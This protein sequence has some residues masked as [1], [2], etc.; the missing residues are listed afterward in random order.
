MGVGMMSEPSEL[1]VMRAFNAACGTAAIVVVYLVARRTHPNK[2]VA[3]I[4]ALALA[5]SPTAVAYSQQVGPDTFALVFALVSFLFAIRIVDDP[6]TRSYVGAGVGAGLAIASKYNAG[7]ILIALVAAHLVRFGWRGIWRKEL[8]IGMIATALAF[9]IGVP[10]A[11]FD[12]PNFIEGVRWQIF[13]YSVEGHAGEEGNALMWYVTYLLTQ[14][15]FAAPVALIGVASAFLARSKKYW[16]VLSFPLF[17]FSIVSQMVT[18]NARTIMLIVPFLG[19]LAAIGVVEACGWLERT[20][21]VKRSITGAILLVIGFLLLIVPARGTL[22]ADRRLTQPDGRESAR[23]WIESNAPLG[24]RIALEAYSPYVD[25]NKF[26]AQG[27]YGLTEHAP[28]WYAAQGFEYLVLSQGAYG[29]YFADP[30]RYPKQVEQYSQFFARYPLAARF[31]DNDWEIRI[32]QT[33]ARLPAQRVAARF[34]DYGELVELIGY[35]EVQWT[36]GVPLRVRLFWRTLGDKP[37]PFEVEL[38]LLDQAD[39]EIARARGD[40]F[41]G[42]GWRTGMFDSAYTLLIPVDVPPSEYRIQVNVIWTRYAYSL[43]AQNWAEQRIDP[44]L[45]QVTRGK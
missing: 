19:L 32:Y 25:R 29:R 37:E 4:S 23:R 2:I 6:R 22:A 17:Y 39:Q 8:Y 9:F 13:S 35:D 20:G 24:S 34:G 1:L 30:A 26:A 38:R 31:D 16:V 12:F 42:K 14:E 45:V 15:G 11:V 44:V 36:P 3:W 41:Q 43:P 27:L 28:E 21:R 40:L 33:D 18:R 5:V 7:M 10:F